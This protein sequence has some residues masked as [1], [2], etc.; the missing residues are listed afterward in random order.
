MSDSLMPFFWVAIALPILLLLQR[1]IQTHL[2]GISLLLTGKP[3]RALYLY[4]IV[5]FP[6]VLLH[7]PEM[8]R[9]RHRAGRQIRGG[10][11]SR[12]RPSCSWFGIRVAGA[13]VLWPCV[14]VPGLR[15]NC[16]G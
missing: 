5:L 9:S 16:L 13:W 4:A 3:E 7:S 14:S 10:R 12:C 11:H 6:G 2:H 8:W 1:W 15:S